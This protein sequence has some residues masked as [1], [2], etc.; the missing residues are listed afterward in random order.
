MRGNKT[1]CFH[2]KKIMS[3]MNKLKT[4]IMQALD[5]F[6]GQA[7]GYK[8]YLPSKISELMSELNVCFQCHNSYPI[9]HVYE[10]LTKK[11]KAI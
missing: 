4:E 11:T 1:G 10:N 6:F 3:V 9:L 5:D 2:W 7:I 8:I